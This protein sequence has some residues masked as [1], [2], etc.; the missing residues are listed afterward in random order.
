MAQ[1]IRDLAWNE[2]VSIALEPRAQA[3]LDLIH[4]AHPLDVLGRQLLPR[5]KLDGNAK[6]HPSQTVEAKLIGPKL[7]VAS[8]HGVSEASRWRMTVAAGA[9]SS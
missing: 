6:F 5:L 4:V 1:Q 2:V 8:D 3:L 7:A 9:E